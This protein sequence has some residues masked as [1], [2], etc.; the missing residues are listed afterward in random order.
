VIEDVENAAAIALNFLIGQI[1]FSMKSIKK[2]DA[3]IKPTAFR[4]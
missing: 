2:L 1:T 3:I 4:D